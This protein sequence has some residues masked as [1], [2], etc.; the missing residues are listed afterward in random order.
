MKTISFESS[1]LLFCD[2]KSGN[3]TAGVAALLA[4]N[5]EIVYIQMWHFEVQLNNYCL[6]KTDGSFYKCDGGFL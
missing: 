1:E 4:N 2:L 3:T 5:I 6:M